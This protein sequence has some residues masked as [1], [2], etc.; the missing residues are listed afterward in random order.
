MRL[1]LVIFYS[2]FGFSFY[3][4]QVP[5]WSRLPYYFEDTCLATA[6]FLCNGI[7]NYKPLIST[8]STVV[9]PMENPI[10]QIC[11]KC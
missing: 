3:F 2:L 5:L 11:D 4:I 10:N 7:C 8:L 9:N 1:F 6:S